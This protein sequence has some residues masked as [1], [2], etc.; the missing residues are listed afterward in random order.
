MKNQND[1]K[2][3]TLMN[4]NNICMSICG[5]NLDALQEELSKKIAPAYVRCGMGSKREKVR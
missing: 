2:S 3:K 5:T 4:K 1:I